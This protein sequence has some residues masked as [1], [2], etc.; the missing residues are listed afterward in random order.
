[1]INNNTDILFV[2][3]NTQEKYI[4]EHENP[5]L[6]NEDHC[7]EENKYTQKNFGGM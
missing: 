5:I 7:S 4:W 1:M 3:K 2:F 6:F